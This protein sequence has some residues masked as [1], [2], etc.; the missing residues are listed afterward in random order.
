M[1]KP[2]EHTE[3]LTSAQTAE[4]LGFSE[5]TVRLSRT[6]GKLAGVQAPAF[7]KMGRNVRYKKADLSEWLGQFETFT[8]TAQAGLAK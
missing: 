5:Y 8:S 2:S 4:F 3:L 6:T 1:S 7:I